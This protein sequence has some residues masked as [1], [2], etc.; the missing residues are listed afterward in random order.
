MISKLSEN[1]LLSVGISPK[2][3]KDEKFR[4]YGRMSLWTFGYIVHLLGLSK[5]IGKTNL[6]MECKPEK[7][8]S[9]PLQFFQPK[10]FLAMP[11]LSPLFWPLSIVRLALCRP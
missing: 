9:S 5:L 10:L 4:T 8:R 1:R 6:A 11:C 3:M 7:I 2:V